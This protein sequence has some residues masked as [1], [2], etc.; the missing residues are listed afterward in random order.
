MNFWA[1]RV[2]VVP[3]QPAAPAA[4]VSTRPW[5]QAG[6]GIQVQQQPQVV[7][8]PQPQVQQPQPQV[9]QAP[10]GKVPIEVLLQ[11]EE[12]TTTKAQSAK[13]GEPC[14]DCGS[15]RYMRSS[16][17]PNSLK[18]CFD[19]GFNPRFLHSTHGASGIGQKDLPVHT[20]RGQI[21]SPGWNPQTIIGRVGV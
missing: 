3:Q 4:P 16:Q 7:Q 6:Q 2:G 8:Q 21:D 9:Q 19:C 11:Q 13:D 18:Q 20:A 12:Y 1:N 15:V 14:P 17:Q 10:D 5:W